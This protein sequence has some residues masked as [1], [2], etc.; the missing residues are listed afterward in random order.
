[1]SI[2]F[3]AYLVLSPGDGAFAVLYV[4]GFYALFAGALYLALGYRLRGIDK[5]LHETSSTT[6]AA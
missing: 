2:V 1:V 5:A 3:G 4:I 6:A